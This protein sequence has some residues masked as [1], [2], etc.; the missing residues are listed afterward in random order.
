MM[1]R[2]V[3]KRYL[4]YIWVTSEVFPVTGWVSDWATS[5]K[6]ESFFV[7]RVLYDM[8]FYFIVIIIVLNLIF[9]VIIDT[10]ADLRYNVYPDFQG[11]HDVLYTYTVPGNQSAHDKLNQIR[12]NYTFIHH[13]NKPCFEI[14]CREWR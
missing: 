6:N 14:L 3:L 13:S 12:I 7:F 1:Y 5:I 2:K 11:T 8:L 9:G 10:F 4:D